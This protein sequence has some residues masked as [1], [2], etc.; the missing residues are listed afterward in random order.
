M[1]MA[2]VTMVPGTA[3]RT[4]RRIVCVSGPGSPAARTRKWTRAASFVGSPCS[5][6]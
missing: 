6:T 1:V 2:L 4:S 3:S 5:G